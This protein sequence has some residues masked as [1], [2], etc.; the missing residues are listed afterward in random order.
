MH[1]SCIIC[2]QLVT[3]TD[4]DT[5]TPATPSYPQLVE[6]CCATSIFVHGGLEYVHPSLSACPLHKD[7]SQHTHT[8]GT[9]LS[10]AGEIK[11]VL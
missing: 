7:V 5:D 9:V 11:Q 8:T 3:S 1:S 4:E 6:N 10:V 2:Q